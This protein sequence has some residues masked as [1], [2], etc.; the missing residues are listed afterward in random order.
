M[1]NFLVRL[2]ENHEAVGFFAVEDL[3][4]LAFWVDEVSDPSVCEYAEIGSGSV[5][6]E[7]KARK[8]PDPAHDW[9]S[10]K[11]SL[12]N[13]IGKHELGGEWGMALF[14]EDLVFEPF[15]DGL[16]V[17]AANEP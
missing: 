7:G 10:E 13:A 16:M 12:L 1:P 6:W 14:D 4:E 17:V 5:I 9:D 8:V 15:H 11:L 2:R 3:E